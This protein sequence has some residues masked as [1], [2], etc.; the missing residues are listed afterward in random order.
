MVIGEVKNWWQKR[1]LKGLWNFLRGDVQ[2]LNHP[3]RQWAKK[4]LAGKTV[5]D[6][7]CGA[8]VDYE[9]LK[10]V[11]E[12]TG[13]D[14][15]PKMIELC[16][17]NFP[18]GVWINSDLRSMPFSDKLFDV[19]YCRAVLEHLDDYRAAIDEM[20]RVGRSVVIVLFHPIAEREHIE[21]IDDNTWNNTY[22]KRL[23]E[24]LGD[25]EIVELPEV[26]YQILIWPTDKVK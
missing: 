7:G 2:G 9:L 20:K 19:V 16:K 17:Q 1:S 3:A 11:C 4:Y 6:V 14:V 24:Y 10:D 12:Y 8:G 5:L 23:V 13:L 26:N 25:C 18:Q 22:D 21:K 15:T